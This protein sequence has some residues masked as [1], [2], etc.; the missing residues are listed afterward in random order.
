MARVGALHR[1]VEN[2]VGRQRV[3]GIDAHFAAVPPVRHFEREKLHRGAAVLRDFHRLGFD[4]AMVQLERNAARRLGRA[5]TRD[6]GQHARLAAVVHAPRRHH[7]L[8]REVGGC[9]RLQWV[10]LQSHGRIQPEIVEIGG[11]AGL[12]HI[13]IE[14][15]R[16][17]QV[18]GLR[19]GAQRTRQ[20]RERRARV[21]AFYGINAGVERRVIV[22]HLAHRLHARTER[23]HLRAL[24]RSQPRHHAPGHLLCLVQPVAGAHAEGVIDREH[25]HFPRAA[26]GRHRLAHVRMRE[27]QHDQQD[28][29]RAQRE[30]HQVAQPPVLDRALYPPLEEHQGAEGQRCGLVFLQK[31]QP[32]R[33]SHRHRAGQ[34]PG[35][36]ETHLEP[37]LAHGQ[38]FPQPFIQRPRR[39][40][41]EVFHPRA[42]RRRG[43]R[44]N[45]RIDLPRVLVARILGRNFQRIGRVFHIHQHHRLAKLRLHL[46]P[47][48]GRE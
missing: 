2:V 44:L 30:Q 32:D 48:T 46:L 20:F 17:R 8:Y 34:K 37:P 19:D 13:R 26:G 31:M 21:G 42:A 7:V 9:L 4:H 43:Q 39:I 24:P 14:V 16:Q 6:G 5:K 36:E 27:R 23:Q 3:G 11:H 45:V 28:Q 15:H 35:R 41:E 40:H 38:V 22:G 33:Q 10:R 29:R 18:D 25:G 47:A 1:E 12:L